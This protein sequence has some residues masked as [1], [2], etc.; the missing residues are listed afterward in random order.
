MFSSGQYLG[1]FLGHWE[2]LGTAVLQASTI[3]STPS[4]KAV[5]FAA[6]SPQLGVPSRVITVPQQSLTGFLRQVADASPPVPSPPPAPQPMP[7]ADLPTLLK[8]VPLLRQPSRQASKSS[9][10]PEKAANLDSSP[11]TCQQLVA[12]CQAGDAA[13][14]MRLL[15]ASADPDAAA[16]AGAGAAGGQPLLLAASGGHLPIVEALLAAGADPNIVREGATPMTAAFQKGH[17]EVLRALFGATFQS[18][19]SAV[20]TNGAAF[21]SPLQSL[22]VTEGEGVTDAMLEEVVQVAQ[23]FVQQDRSFDGRSR[24]PPTTGSLSRIQV[25]TIDAELATCIR[26]AAV[27]DAIK[28]IVGTANA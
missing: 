20:Q 21:N 27:K 3:M 14:V 23:R 1:E 13:A 11:Q 5:T 22:P 10:G 25:K 24:R 8:E 17:Q 18:L 9:R 7:G 28:S 15:A 12:A 2:A 16:A 19:G 4:V 6:G 26:S